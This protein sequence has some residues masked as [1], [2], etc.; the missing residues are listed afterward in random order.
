MA[1]SHRLFT[2]PVKPETFIYIARLL[3][4]DATLTTTA[5]DAGM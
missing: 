1:M 4:P 3:L 2:L 5:R